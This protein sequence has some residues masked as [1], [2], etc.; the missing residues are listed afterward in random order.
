[1]QKKTRI[2]LCSGT[3]CYLMAGSELLLLE[4]H[5]PP[6]LRQQVAI[7]GR[8]CLELCKRDQLATAPYV[9][10]DGTVFSGATLPAV[11]ERISRRATEEE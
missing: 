9:L 3:A 6:G 7:E 8:P 2:T 10:I 11:L 1:M 4:S 5:L